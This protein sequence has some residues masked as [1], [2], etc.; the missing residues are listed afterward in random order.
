MEDD[1]T[2][3]GKQGNDGP[4]E[5]RQIIGLSAG[6]P[7][8]VL[9]HFLVDPVAA[10][11]AD[12]VLNGM[13]TGQRPPAHQSRRNQ[14]P[15]RVTDS[16]DRLACVLH[17]LQKGLHFRYHAQFVGVDCSA[18]KMNGIK[19]CRADIPDHAIDLDL[20]ALSRS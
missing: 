16:S 14:F 1:G 4:I 6:H 15:W 19:F 5:R 3:S 18:G 10:R 9:N 11:I 12:V 13:T 8:A 2:T 17:R 20:T 7:I